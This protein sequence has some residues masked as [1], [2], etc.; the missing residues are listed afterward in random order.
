MFDLMR[1]F[2][3]SSETWNSV[4]REEDSLQFIL[5]LDSAYRQPYNIESNEETKTD[6][7]YNIYTDHT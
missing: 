5:I 3:V 1:V 4:W 2:Y 6:I 7:T